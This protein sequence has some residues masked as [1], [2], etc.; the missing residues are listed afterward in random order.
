LVI[1]NNKYNNLSAIKSLLDSLTHVS[2]DEQKAIIVGLI[3][4]VSLDT[5]FLHMDRTLWNYGVVVDEKLDVMRM[6][7]LHDNSYVLFLNKGENY[8]EDAIVQ[9]INAGGMGVFRPGHSSLDLIF[10]GDD[11]I[12]QLI[13]FYESSDDDVRTLID[14]VIKNLNVDKLVKDTLEVC[15]IG[16]VPALWVKAVLNFRQKTILK[17]IESVKIKN[18]VAQMPNVTFSKRK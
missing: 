15:K 18:D 6:A 3:Q 11:S 4:M 5:V 2:L 16:D 9:F 17:G 13:A 1:Q 8:I 7:E 12:D 10:D 14:S